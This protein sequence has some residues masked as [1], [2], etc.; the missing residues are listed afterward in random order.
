VLRFGRWCIL[1]FV[2][3]YGERRIIGA[4]LVGV[5]GMVPDTRFMLELG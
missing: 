5:A 1:A 2:S 4:A 3:V